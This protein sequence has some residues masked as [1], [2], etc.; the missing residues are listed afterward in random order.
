MNKSKINVGRKK[1]KKD[2]FMSEISLMDTSDRLTEEYL[3]GHEGFKSEILNTTRFDKIS[4]ISMTYLGRASMVRDHKMVADERFSMSEQWYTTGMLLNGTE[5]QILLDTR[6]SKSFMSKSHYLCCKSLHSLPKFTSKIQRIQ[7]GN[8]QYVSVLSVIPIII[9][10][11]SHRCEIYTLVSEIHEN[12]DI[13]LGIKNVFE[14]EDV[15]N[16]WEC[17]FSFLNRSIPIFPKEGMVLKLKEQKLVKIEAPSLDEISGLAIV[18]LLDKS[19]Q[20]IIMLKVKFMQNAA[21]LDM[22]NSGLETLILNLEEVLGIL[23][24]RSL[25]YYKIW[26]GVLQQNLSRFYEFESAEKVCNQFNNLIN[27][28]KKEEK[29]KTGENTHG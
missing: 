29:L 9:D 18:K 14:L 24:L 23:D 15:I 4:D 11:H 6:A 2:R 16:L 3:D 17:C 1:G 21:M 22:M 8:G 19:T 12:V 13:V 28:L 25:G 10:I 5:C 26:Q 7:V 20:S 27:T